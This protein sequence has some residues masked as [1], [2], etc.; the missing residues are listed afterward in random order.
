MT[1]NEIKQ[2]KFEGKSDENLNIKITETG[3]KDMGRGNEINTMHDGSRKQ[4]QEAI[5]KMKLPI[6]GIINEMEPD[7]TRDNGSS[8]ETEKRPYLAKRHRRRS[9]EARMPKDVKYSSGRKRKHHHDSNGN[10]DYPD[11]DDYIPANYEQLACSGSDTS[12][13]SRSPSSMTH[14]NEWSEIRDRWHRYQDGRH[15]NGRQKIGV[16]RRPFR[17]RSYQHD[18]VNYSPYYTDFGRPYRTYHPVTS[19]AHSSELFNQ[20]LHK[21]DSM[22]V[23]LDAI[24]SLLQ[25]TVKILAAPVNEG[26]QQQQLHEREHDVIHENRWKRPRECHSDT[27]LD[28]E[29]GTACGPRSSTNVSVPHVMNGLRKEDSYNGNEDLSHSVRKKDSKKNRPVVGRSVAQKEQQEGIIRRENEELAPKI[30]SYYSM[31]RNEEF[32]GRQENGRRNNEDEPLHGRMSAGNRN[33]KYSSQSEPNS[34]SKGYSFRGETRVNKDKQYGESDG[35]EDGVMRVEDSGAEVVRMQGKDGQVIEDNDV[36]TFTV[37]PAYMKENIEAKDTKLSLKDGRPSMVDLSQT[38]NKMMLNS[39]YSMTADVYSQVNRQVDQRENMEIPN[40]YREE[41][42]PCIYPESPW[43]KSQNMENLNDSF[44]SGSSYRRRDI[45]ETKPWLARTFKTGSG[46]NEDLPRGVVTNGRDGIGERSSLTDN[47]KM[48]SSITHLILSSID[49]SSE[50]VQIL[51]ATPSDHN[52]NKDHSRKSMERLLNQSLSF[53]GCLPLIAEI[54]LSVVQKIFQSSKNCMSFI[55]RLMDHCYTREELMRCRVAGGVR[56]YRGNNTE[57][58]QL[59]P[60]RLRTVL[61]LASDLFP[62]EYS[63]LSKANMIRNNINM[64]CRKTV[65]RDAAN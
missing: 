35:L 31:R 63:K 3:A 46:H 1:S 18:T 56:R 32:E 9:N 52:S 4:D 7:R 2:S 37:S 25:K 17:P 28:G 20:M 42:I 34:D 39:Y 51:V 40:R 12:D 41:D 60:K 54:D 5:D 59:C 61:K 47:K 6:T 19:E 26:K 33:G 45:M 57:T 53:M 58:E 10:I 22:L 38:S 15:M 13:G 65:K 49:V 23:R 55:Y 62:N 16:K 64:K 30:A 11:S 48:M 29:N 27:E 8:L 36:T 44:S 50:I 43:R 24:V 21:Q 14:S